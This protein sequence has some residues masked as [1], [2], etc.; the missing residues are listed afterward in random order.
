[1]TPTSPPQ[2][3]VWSQTQARNSDPPHSI[4]VHSGT[5]RSSNHWNDLHWNGGQ[6]PPEDTISPTAQCSVKPRPLQPLCSLPLHCGIYN[7]EPPG[8]HRV[9]R[10]GQL[11]TALGESRWLLSWPQLARRERGRLFIFAKGR[12]TEWVRL[13][14]VCQMHGWAWREGLAAFSLLNLI[15]K[16]LSCG[17]THPSSWAVGNSFNK[18]TQWSSC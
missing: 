9:R 3:S 1:M 8:N 5:G 12:E 6:P 17:L 18:A 13:Q 7:S 2:N 14:P 16:S 10:W 4:L 15:G 11:F